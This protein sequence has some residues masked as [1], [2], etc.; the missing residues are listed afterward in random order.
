[1][2]RDAAVTLDF[3]DGSYRFR[4]GYKELEELQE[5]VDAGPWYLLGQFSA[6]SQMLVNPSA[7]RGLTV[8]MPREIIRIGLIGGGMK[9]ADALRLVRLYVDERPP[10]ESISVAFKVLTAALRGA[11]DE[12]DIKK[13]VEGESPST[14]YPEE[15]SDLAKSME[16]G[17]Q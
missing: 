2:S 17:P 9:P 4:L 8:R 6:L 14:T 7:V 3:A 13:K 16:Q 5:S 1:M 12:A 11:D 10:D 15:S